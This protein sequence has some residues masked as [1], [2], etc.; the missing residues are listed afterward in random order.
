MYCFVCRGV[1][2]TANSQWQHC[3]P[4]LIYSVH[5]SSSP[6]GYERQVRRPRCII[7][8]PTR[9]LARQILGSIKDL[10][11]FSKVCKRYIVCATLNLIP[12]SR[13]LALHLYGSVTLLLFAILL[14]HVHISIPQHWGN[15]HVC[16]LP[17]PLLASIFILTTLLLD[18]QLFSLPLL[19]PCAMTKL[20]F[21][22]N[23]LR[24]IPEKG[25][26]VCGLYFH[27]SRL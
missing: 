17:L 4:H 11:H 14:I 7:L 8:V 26:A 18:Q 5:F 9:D 15:T 13:R 19:S 25:E 24:P 6:K 20:S 2:I 16:A 10:S 12:S 22:M 3:L 27:R 1:Y 21:N 23:C